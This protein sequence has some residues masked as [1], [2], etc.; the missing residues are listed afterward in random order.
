MNVLELMAELTNLTSAEYSELKAAIL[1]EAKT[2]MVSRRRSRTSPRSPLR[3]TRPRSS[4]PRPGTVRRMA[5]AGRRPVRS[6]E[7]ADNSRNRATLVASGNLRGLDAGEVITDRYVFWEGAR[8]HA[9]EHGPKRP[10][11]R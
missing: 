7:R 2:S 11:G 9:R 1:A 4:A 3:R 10:A 5:A 6:P 8:G